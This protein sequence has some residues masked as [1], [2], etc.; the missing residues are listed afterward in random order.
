MEK[1]IF[2]L[3]ISIVFL[4]ICVVYIP[5]INAAGIRSE[6][7]AVETRSLDEFTGVVVLGYGNV[8]IKSGDSFSI[9]IRGSRDVIQ[10][11]ITEVV[12]NTLTISQKRVSIMKIRKQLL[13]YDI[14]LPELKSLKIK[15]SSDVFVESI[16]TDTFDLQL[17]GSGDVFI[18]NALVNSFM[19]MSS[20]SG[21]IHMA[22]MMVSTRADLVLRGSGDTKISS[23]ST[24]ILDI[25]TS[26][27]G[28]MNF[29]HFKGNT[30]TLESTGSG[31]VDLWASDTLTIESN[32]SGNISYYAA[33][34]TTITTNQT[35]SATIK[36]LGEK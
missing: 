4:V 28:N 18:S 31:N 24:P 25:V 36:S 8:R 17:T 10:N 33:A 9:T 23:G 32:G 14:V 19:I 5:E 35:G 12:N 29:K 27:S 20:A 22:K 30:V 21:D 3:T 26:G 1:K 2:T 15:H 16:D 34:G 7:M 6:N 13:E 11:I